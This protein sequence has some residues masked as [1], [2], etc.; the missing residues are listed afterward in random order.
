MS[1]EMPTY[2]PPSDSMQVFIVAVKAKLDELNISQNELARRSSMQSTHVSKLL[3]GQLGNC[4]LSKCDAIASALG[5]TT[6][7]LLNSAR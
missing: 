4:T 1:T 6:I 7:D 5:T 3:R 2:A